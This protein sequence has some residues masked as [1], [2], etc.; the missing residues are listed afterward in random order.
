M[1]LPG[2]GSRAVL[3]C[4]GTRTR[5][6][7]TQGFAL[8]VES[9]IYHGCVHFPASN[10]LEESYVEAQLLPYS[11][12]PPTSSTSSSS[13]AA[14]KKDISFPPLAIIPSTYHFLIL[15]ASRRLQLINKLTGDIVADC[16]PQLD[17]ILAPRLPLPSAS[18]FGLGGG[19][20]HSGDGGRGGA[21]VPLE[22]LSGLAADPFT[23]GFYMYSDQTLLR[24]P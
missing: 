7:T 1:E 5:S 14:A 13:S 8:M 24:V 2:G 16:D 9:G 15:T 19:S 3:H 6:S 22:V 4:Y 17:G 11:H 23:G 18:S 21:K 10:S 12:A 20:R